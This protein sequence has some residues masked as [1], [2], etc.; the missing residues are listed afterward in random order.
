MLCYCGSQKVYENCCGPFLKGIA[1]PATAEALM[2]SR[3]SAFVECQIPY[4]KKT[5]SEESQSDFNQ[6]ETKKWAS[7][8]K[9]QGLEI[10]STQKGQE[11]DVDGIVE[12]IASYTLNGEEYKHHEVSTFKKDHQGHWVFVD[13]VSPESSRAPVVHEGPKIGRNDPCTC[14][15]G[16]KYK[17][18]C[19]S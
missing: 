4:L 10:I 18:C 9:W 7:Q 16:K 6:E 2:R 19:G 14:G 11:S 17:K 8:A 12:F 3:Y 13:G 5:L 15:S 1:F